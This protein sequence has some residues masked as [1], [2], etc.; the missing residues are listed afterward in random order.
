MLQTSSNNGL[1]LHIHYQH[2]K[3]KLKTMRLNKKCKENLILFSSLR[4]GKPVPYHHS[5][6][7]SKQNHSETATTSA[8]T[9]CLF[10]Q[11]GLSQ[12]HLCFD[13]SEALSQQLDM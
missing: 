9:Q 10:Q 11:S 8:K 4:A 13:I 6:E 3:H 12:P 5:R 7:K 2:Y 1:H